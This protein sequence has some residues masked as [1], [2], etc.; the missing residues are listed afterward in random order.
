MRKP[1]KSYKRNQ[2]VVGVKLYPIEIQALEVIAD[3]AGWDHK[4][5]A[6][7]E[8]MKIWVECAIIA[9]EEKKSHKAMLQMLKSM[10]RVNKQIDTI[11]KNAKKSRE[12]D[13]LFESNLEVLKE[14]LAI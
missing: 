10:H 6:L 14:A 9:I 4:S 7:R 2:K 3:L 1:D 12:E 11:S 13:M 8:F 5:T